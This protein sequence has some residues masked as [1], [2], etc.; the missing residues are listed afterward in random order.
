MQTSEYKKDGPKVTVALKI[1]DRSKPVERD[2]VHCKVVAVAVYG[3]FILKGK[4]IPLECIKVGFI[5]SPTKGDLFTTGIPEGTDSIIMGDSFTARTEDGDVTYTLTVVPF[6]MDSFRAHEANTFLWGTMRTH[7]ASNLTPD[8]YMGAAAPDLASC[9]FG[10][11]TYNA[12]LDK[13]FGSL[14]GDISVQFSLNA[15]GT[16]NSKDCKKLHKMTAPDGSPMRFEPSRAFLDAFGLTKCCL[17]H[18]KSLC[19]CD[20]GK[21]RPL[22]AINRKMARANHLAAVE[23]ILKKNKIERPVSES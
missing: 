13:T 3:R 7:K 11:T 17:A 10:V 23:R 20:R 14:T 6:S 5:S 12:I 19:Y 16:I 4:D 15:A 18:E 2:N 22:S 9:G 1:E 21:A 8:E